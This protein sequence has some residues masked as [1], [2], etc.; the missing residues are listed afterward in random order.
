MKKDKISVI[1][2]VVGIF[3]IAFLM[4][5]LLGL[6][7]FIPS[8]KVK[9]D[10]SR[11]NDGKTS[12]EIFDNQHKSLS[13]SK[14]LG[15]EYVL[16]D[17]MPDYLTNAFVCLEDKRFFEHNGI[18][19]YRIAGA[20]VENI[21]N[22]RLKEGASTITQQLIKNTHLSNEK[23]FSRKFAELRLA[24][25]LEKE[26]SKEKI[27]EVYLN[28]I[29]F[30][31]DCY[32][33]S[34]ASKY[35]FDKSVKDLTLSESAVL[36]GLISAP[37][38]YAPDKNM[39]KCLMRRNL[40]LKTMLKQ[41]KISEKEYE[42]AINER[43]D[44]NRIGIITDIN[45]DYADMV[46]CEVSQLLGLTTQQV[47]HL[48]LKIYTFLNQE[49]QQSLVESIKKE[50]ISTVSGKNAQKMAISINNNTCG[51][52]AFFA[53]SKTS[54]YFLCRQ[55]GSTAKPIVCLAPSFEQNLITPSSYILDEKANFGGYQPSNSSDKYDGWITV[56]QAIAKSKNVPAV[57]LLNA[58]NKDLLKKDISDIWGF[59]EKKEIQLNM[60]LGSFDQGL[61]IKQLAESYLML[62]NKGKFATCTFIK[63]I[64]DQ[65]GNVLYD[66][67]DNKRQVF[68]DDSAFLTTQVLKDVVKTGTARNLNAEYEAAGKTGTVGKKGCVNNSDA[69]FAS[70]TS[71]DTTV[72]WVFA[73]YDDLLQSGVMGSSA[74]VDMAKNY[75]QMIYKKYKPKNFEQPN[76]VVKMKIDK[77]LLQQN[78]KVAIANNTLPQNEIVEEYFS[79][80]NLPKETSD[81]IKQEQIEIK[82]NET[83]NYLEDFLNKLKKHPFWDVFCFILLQFQYFQLLVQ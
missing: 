15:D 76:S 56:R 5:F 20:L 31:N 34:P 73:D 79:K 42:V 75:Y 18:D 6:Y 44:E 17:E 53:N 2:I 33:I 29:Y 81:R 54:P 68:R 26:M 66:K 25:Q 47:K 69:I 36:A 50:K 61:T 30:G 63:R 65:N 71:Q 48:N 23:T 49:K 64:E 28:S 62:A 82:E 57:K 39:D 22:M 83:R 77:V 43:I 46:V 13:V 45:K 80:F 74:P 70:Y 35:Y 4:I 52:E 24:R 11:F 60:A 59:D 32:G 55:I 78:K 38:I 37:S 16:I 72:F 1:K 27:L 12:V 14:M 3:L 67:N 7:F 19:Y 21:K 51:V 10:L 9:L 41:N 8:L 40:T 58:L